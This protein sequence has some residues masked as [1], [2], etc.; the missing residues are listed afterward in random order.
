MDAPCPA[1]SS[2]PFGF[3]GHSDLAVQTIGDARLSLQCRRCDSF[4]SRTY[5]REGYFTWAAITERMAASPFMGI[6]VPP[7]S[8]DSDLRPLP[9]RGGGSSPWVT[10]LRVGGIGNTA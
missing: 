1:C 7:L 9:W 4:W 6:A 8:T 10:A 5:A 3:A 2:G